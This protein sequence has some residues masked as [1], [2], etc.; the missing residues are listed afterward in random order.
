MIPTPKRENFWVETLKFTVIALLIVIPFR[1]FI[2]QPF[3]VSGESMAPTFIDGQYLIV[4]EIS[5]RF[6]PPARGDVLVFKY[7][8]DKSK[9]F[10]KRVIGLPGETVILENGTVSIKKGETITVLNEPYVE[11]KT[12]DNMTVTLKKDQYFV[13]GD[14]RP[15]SLDSRIW[16]PLSKK[17]I[18]GR[19][20]ARLL[21]FN[22]MTLFPGAYEQPQPSK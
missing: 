8:Y 18:I 4:D 19:P 3:V 17:L 15:E 16:G 6:S 21:P 10:I 13:L 5:Y 7:P 22:T 11:S 20:V 9:D 1:Y 2:A 14:N 12:D